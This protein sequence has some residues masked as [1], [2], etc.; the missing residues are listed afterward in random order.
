VWIAI[1][2]SCKKISVWIDKKLVFPITSNAPLPNPDMPEDVLRDFNEARLLLQFSSRAACAI[3]R[4][5]VEKITDSLI[6]SN[7]SLNE[8]IKQ[9]VSTGLDEDIQKALDAVRVIGSET[10]HPLQMDLKD[11]IDTANSL[12][13]IVNLIVE[14]TISRKKKLKTCMISFPKMLKMSL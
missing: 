5:C 1:C 2:Y 4:L 3:L 12:F 10:I 11:D 7:A 14:S 8:K 9:L 6:S 13:D